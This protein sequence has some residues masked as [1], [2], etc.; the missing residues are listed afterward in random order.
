MAACSTPEPANRRN[1]LPDIEEINSSLRS[2]ADHD[3][4]AGYGAE[5]AELLRDRSRY[6]AGFI[7]ALLVFVIGVVIYAFAP[8]IAAMFPG[9]EG[10]LSGYVSVINALRVSLDS[11]LQAAIRGISGLLD[12]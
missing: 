1:L 4:E 2:D 8:M 10:I 7:L 3:A 9:A 5:E 11:V 6:R 12:G